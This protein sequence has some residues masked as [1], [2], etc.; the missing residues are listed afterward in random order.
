MCTTTNG[1]RVNCKVITMRNKEIAKGMLRLEWK[2]I[3]FCNLKLYADS[4]Q[5]SVNHTSGGSARCGIHFHLK[6][7]VITSLEVLQLDTPSC[8]PIQPF[9]ATVEAFWFHV[10]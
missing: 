10:C 2:R 6:F 5:G 1:I 8:I 9:V 3:E 7:L 4:G